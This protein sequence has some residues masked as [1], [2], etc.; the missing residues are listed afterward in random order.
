MTPER[1]A[2][3]KKGLFE[4]FAGTPIEQAAMIIRFF[5]KQEHIS[6]LEARIQERRDC[7]YLLESDMMDHPRR[8][9]EYTK[10]MKDEI[11]NHNAFIQDF[12]KQLLTLTSP[13]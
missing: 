1:L 6:V 5:E 10:C 13:T 4:I 11:S 12:E 8:N 2:T 9:P 7:I 3:L